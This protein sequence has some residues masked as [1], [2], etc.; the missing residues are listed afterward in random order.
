MGLL[1]NPLATD[2]KYLAHHRENLKT[3]IQMQ[4]SQKQKSFSQS[5]AEF[6]KSSENFK[7]FESK[8]EPH[9]FCIFEVT[10]SENLV[11]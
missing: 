11:T 1:V 6:L 8:D 4:L 2:E 3:P 5:F 7:Y 9:R 10:D